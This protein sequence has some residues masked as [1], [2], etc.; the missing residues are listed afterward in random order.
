[1]I[2]HGISIVATVSLILLISFVSISDVYCLSM[3]LLSNRRDAIVTITTATSSFFVWEN[4]VPVTLATSTENYQ[5]GPD[6]LKYLITR[7]GTGQ[8][9]QRGQKIETSYTLWIN[10]F[11]GEG[12]PGAAKKIDSSK[13][14]IVGDQPF[15]VR[16][17]VSQ[18]IRGWDLALLDM[19]EG[20][21]R[22]LIVPPELGYGEKGIGPIPP[23]CTLYFEMT[24][25][26]VEP[27]EELLPEAKKW[28][29][30]NPL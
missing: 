30:E 7:E 11:P 4:N 9:P 6:G 27:F 15:K 21:S 16:V 3:P 10:S 22:K 28:L 8:K 18:V 24:L 23:K 12:A 17:G 14:P 2:I 13:K 20:E 1:M 19:K 25:T 29:E 26:K 5:E